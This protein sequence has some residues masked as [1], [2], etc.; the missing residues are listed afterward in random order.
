MFQ[1]VIYSIV[2]I[3]LLE[4]LITY[5]N[6]NDRQNINFIK[7]DKILIFISFFII[8]RFIKIYNVGLLEFIYS[9]FAIY[10]IITAYIDL[11]TLYIYSIVNRVF[12]IIVAIAFLF[13]MDSI[14]MKVFLIG[15]GA[16]VIIWGVNKFFSFMGSGDI[17]IIF[18]STLVLSTKNILMIEEY[19]IIYQFLFNPITIMISFSIFLGGLFYLLKIITNGLRILKENKEMAFSPF[20]AVSSFFVLIFL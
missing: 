14:N 18:I 19:S 6:I 2:G 15:I 9:L 11:K 13:T 5:I 12:L 8:L 4:L 1:E 7:R 10:L 17:D 16:G 3:V 20:L